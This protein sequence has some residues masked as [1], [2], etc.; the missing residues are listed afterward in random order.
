MGIQKKDEIIIKKHL[1]ACCEC[2]K[3]KE[4]NEVGNSGGCDFLKLS[5]KQGVLNLLDIDTVLLD[6]SS[7]GVA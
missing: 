6:A 5:R 4:C 7:D 3:R 2:K 1:G